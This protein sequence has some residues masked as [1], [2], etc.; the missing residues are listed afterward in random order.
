MMFTNTDWAGNSVSALGMGCW[1][2][3]G[4][5]TFDGRAVGWGPSD[6][7]QS[8]AAIE[9]A[10]DAGIRVF[11]TAQAY[12]TGHSEKLLGDTLSSRPEARIVTKIG[13]GID[14]ASRSITGPEVTAD[15]LRNSLDGSL[16]R[17]KRDQIDLALLHLNELEPNDAVPIF[18]WLEQERQAGRIAAYG[19]STDFPDHATAF[20]SVDGFKAVECAVN[21]FF[22]ADTLLPQLKTHDLVPLIRS[23]LA[24]GLL[25]GRIDANTRFDP[26]DVRATDANWMAYFEDG[27]PNPEHLR[28]LDAV[29]EL[30]TTGGRSLAQGAIGWL[31]ALDPRCIPVPGMRTPA[32]VE[33]LVGALH[34]G[35][36]PQDVFDEIENVIIRAPEGA[37]RAR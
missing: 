4:P 3:G 13:L 9:T 36:L 29:R 8:K 33:D 11:D 5:F 12:G 15:A 26:N 27:R 10:Y 37:P 1:A 18:D 31:W 21:L 28:R 30:L 20:A 19:W 34:H 32:H 6:D 14:P 16:R 25:G 24:M 17:L 22:R 23:P 35:P 7:A 2:I